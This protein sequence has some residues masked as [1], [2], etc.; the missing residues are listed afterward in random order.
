M[1]ERRTLDVSHL[2]PYDISSQAP[3]WWGQ[4]CIVCI[5]GT[6]F[7]ILIAAYFY[8]RLR[9]DVWP[10]P[11]DQFPHLLL[12]TLALIPLIASA[13]GSYWASQAAKKDDRRG[14]IIGLL[15]NVVLA[16][17]A[18]AMRLVEWHSLNFN[19]K[20]DAQGSYVWAFLG[21]HSFDYIGDVVFT[22]VL[23]LIILSGRYGEKQRLGVHVDSVVWYFLVAVWI[24]IYVVIYWGPRIVETAQ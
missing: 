23:L 14:M 24:P 12:P 20:T 4:A 10:P 16:A 11:G 5:E 19:W 15:L 17:I 1:I 9:M 2:E 6:M 13:F 7:G 3:L 18:F 22:I 21:L 8:V